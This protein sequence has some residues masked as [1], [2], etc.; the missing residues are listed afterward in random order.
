M[1]H[2]AE[3]FFSFENCVLS[4]LVASATKRLWWVSVAAASLRESFGPFW[5]QRFSRFP[6]RTGS[7]QARCLRVAP[8][9]HLARLQEAAASPPMLSLLSRKTSS[10]HRLVGDLHPAWAREREQSGARDQGVR[11]PGPGTAPSPRRDRERRVTPS[12]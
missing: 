2:F 5:F 8:V 12:L 3:V 1:C 10:G 11:W 4:R 9:Y 6:L 7:S